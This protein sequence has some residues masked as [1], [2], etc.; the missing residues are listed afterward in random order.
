[1]NDEIENDE[2]LQRKTRR[3][4]AQRGFRVT[5]MRGEFHDFW[6][7]LDE[8]VGSVV[9]TRVTLKAIGDFLKDRPI[10]C[11]RPGKRRVQYVERGP[12]H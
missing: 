8:N 2:R 11:K 9:L 5:R 3:E 4:A 7:L 1:M 10:T 6:M 12:L